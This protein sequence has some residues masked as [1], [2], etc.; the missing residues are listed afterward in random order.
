MRKNETGIE[1]LRKLVNMANNTREDAFDDFDLEQTV[2]LL[3][4]CRELNLEVLPD[5]LTEEEA[6]D[7]ASTGRISTECLRRLYRVEGLPEK[8]RDWEGR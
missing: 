7:T 1:E 6:E 8:G 3:R 4:A 5:Q 2:R